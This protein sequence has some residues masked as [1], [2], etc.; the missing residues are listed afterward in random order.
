VASAERARLREA[1]L[2]RVEAQFVPLSRPS[3]LH[4]AFA[5]GAMLMATLTWWVADHQTGALRAKRSSLAMAMTVQV[6]QE[7]RRP[8]PSEPSYRDMVQQS[9]S[10]WPL[11]LLALE[12]VRSPGVVVRRIEIANEAAMVRVELHADSHRAVLEHL[13]ALNAGNTHGGGAEVAWRLERTESLAAAGSGSAVVA[14]LTAPL[15]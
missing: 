15:Q 12:R 4:W 5:V 2:R 9:S 8:N 13:S 3:R 1:G 14:V 11:A 7:A 10:K 6:P